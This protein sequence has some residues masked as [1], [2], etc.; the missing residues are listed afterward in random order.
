MQ[1]VGY[2][3]LGDMSN[4]IVDGKRNQHT[5]LTLS[6]W[7]GN[8]TPTELKADLS[9]QIAINYLESPDYHIDVEAVSNNHFDEDGLISL[10]ALLNPQEALERKQF[11]IDVASAGDF[12]V[13][14][15]RDAA[16]TCFVISAWT[17]PALSPLN[18][19]VFQKPYPELTMML[20]EELL[21]RLDN[22]MD[23]VE[24][25]Q[26]YWI[27]ED[28]VLERSQQQLAAGNITIEEDRQI[29]LAVVTLPHPAAATR[30]QA[31]SEP[32]SDIVHQMAIHNSTSMMR[33]LLKQAN[34]YKLYFRYETWV[35]YV[36]RKT[37][38]RVD[39]AP[40]AAELTKLEA[41]GS[42]WQFGDIA[43]ITPQLML[44]GAAESK[45]SPRDFQ[46]RL[47]SY[48]VSKKN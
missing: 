20:Y 39:M 27:D 24:Y 47:A 22:I 16:R 48:L 12:A 14:S 44:N 18:A 10:W 1:Y 46:D 25:L 34:R 38:P 19:E 11:L 43:D 28:R 2:H 7:P 13:C 15:D 35:E 32:W 4:I 36:S 37:M 40:F 26:Q 21:K 45:I 42:S 41:P 30:D 31:L 29:D 8:D 3:M 5:K 17:K 23:R 9:A 6:H 33:V